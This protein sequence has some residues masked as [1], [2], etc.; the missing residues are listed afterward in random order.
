MRQVSHE[1][2]EAK[3]PTGQKGG[4][5]EEWRLF[6]LINSTLQARSSSL[7]AAL[8]KHHPSLLLL[9]LVIITGQRFYF[10]FFLHLVLSYIT[11]TAHDYKGPI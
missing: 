3:V 10:I 8:V 6:M 4:A 1:K 9:T 2:E 7:M 5:V 11:G